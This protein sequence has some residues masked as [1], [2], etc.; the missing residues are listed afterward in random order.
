MSLCVQELVLLYSGRKAAHGGIP[1][2]VPSTST[3][4][5]GFS[6]FQY[7]PLELCL[8]FHC[9]TSMYHRLHA[10]L[11]LYYTPVPYAVVVAVPVFERHSPHR[12]C[13]VPESRITSTSAAA[14]FKLAPLNRLA[15]CSPESGRVIPGRAVT[16]GEEE[17]VEEVLLPLL[18]K[19]LLE[20]EEEISRP[21]RRF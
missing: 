19:P 7:Q 12:C 11:C 21:Q 14:Y 2:A 17:G 6:P 3:R 16:K 8:L 1:D 15:S 5:C 9:A 18:S 4:R 10:L 13:H 20:D